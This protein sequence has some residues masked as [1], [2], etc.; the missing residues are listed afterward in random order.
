MTLSRK[1]SLMVIFVLVLA[2]P[3]ASSAQDKKNYFVIKG[4]TYTFTDSLKDANFA[5]GFDGELGYGRY[6]LPNLALE[7]A[8]GYFHDGVNKGYGNDIKAIPVTLTAKLVMPLKNFEPFAGI[9]AGFYFAK[10]HGLVN[11]VVTDA[12]K[13]VFGGHAVIGS[14]YNFSSSI[15][16]GVEGRYIVT[17]KTDFGALR[18]SLN[19][20]TATADLG[21]R[22]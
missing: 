4:G 17:E 5:T 3:L 9:G 18:S 1:I 10:F 20:F 12:S 21:Y 14:Y 16:A 2:L 8:V 6:V 13:T 11:E 15:F 19:G 7:G 22:F